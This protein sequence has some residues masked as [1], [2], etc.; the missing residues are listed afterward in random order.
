MNSSLRQ[1]SRVLAVSLLMQLP[2]AFAQSTPDLSGLLSIL[3]T[4]PEGT[5]VQ[6]NLNSYS[7]AWTPE[8]LRPLYLTSNPDPSKIAYAWPSFAWDSNRG[9]LILYGGGHANY[10]GND[11]YR[12]RGTTR[13]GAVAGM[14]A[15]LGVAVYYLLSHV[16][17]VRAALPGWLLADGL[18]FGIQPIS[19]G[20]FGVPAG[21]VAAAV[22][23]RITRPAPVPTGVRLEI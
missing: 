5:W 17:A 18:W 22:V 6:V 2:A 21:F 11:V 23:S 3:N 9:D 13:K 10:S 14:L 8:E 15:G 16:P 19:A 1:A 7:E 12:W 20:V 4:T